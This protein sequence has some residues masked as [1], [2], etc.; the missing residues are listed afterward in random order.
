MIKKLFCATVLSLFTSA[1]ADYDETILQ[2]PPK[3]SNEEKLMSTVCRT[4]DH[5]MWD[6]CYNRHDDGTE[7][8]R[9]FKFSNVGENKIVPKSGFGVG[10]LFEFNFEDLARSDLSL[11]LWDMP[12]EVESHGHLKMMMFF[13]RTYM[14]A[15]NYVSNDQEDS[16]NVTLPTGE[17]VQFNGKTY[18]ITGGV[19]NETPMAQDSEGNGLEPKVN[20]TGTGVVVW[21]HRLNDYPVGVSNAARKKQTAYIAKKGYP[22]CKVS[23]SDLWY[24]DPQ[25]GGNVFFNKKFITDAAFDTYIKKNCKFSMY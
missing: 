6:V 18:E 5:L 10:R 16:V 8:M 3:E 14:F 4:R 13:P 25:K 22:L 11:L 21:A 19:L 12:D 7:S 17:N 9:S 2:A 1:W 20:Y 15:I 23:A 24:T